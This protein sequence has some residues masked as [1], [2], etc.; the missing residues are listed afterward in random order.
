[1]KRVVSADADY[2]FLVYFKALYGQE[3]VFVL[4]C[5][6]GHKKKGTTQLE[7]FLCIDDW[8]KSHLQA[9]ANWLSD[10]K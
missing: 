7:L 9:S 10:H 3:N 2:P 8:I 6:Y 1:M 5:L 4:Q